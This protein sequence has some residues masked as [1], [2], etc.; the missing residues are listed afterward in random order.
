MT[1]GRVRVSRSLYRSALADAIDWTVSLIQAG[2]PDPEDRKRLA[3]YRQALAAL[4]GVA[5]EPEAGSVLLQ[6]VRPNPEVRFPGS[7]RPE[8]GDA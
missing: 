5:P 3:R 2:N 8:S 1:S 7:R 4:G 6:D